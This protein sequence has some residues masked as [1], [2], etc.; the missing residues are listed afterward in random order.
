MEPVFAR[1]LL[2]TSYHR[3]KRSPSAERQRG[4]RPRLLDRPVPAES[5]LGFR[6]RRSTLLRTVLLTRRR[7]H[8]V[9]TIRKD[10][11]ARVA[12]DKIG[13]RRR[14]PNART[15]ERGPESLCRAVLFSERDRQF[16]TPLCSRDI[17]PD[18]ER[19]E[20]PPL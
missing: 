8:V 5:K 7:T 3:R 14:K 15:V 13:V 16:S 20:R 1:S 19:D 2:P 12:E 18:D 4:S 9:V 6:P 11:N 17:P 10:R